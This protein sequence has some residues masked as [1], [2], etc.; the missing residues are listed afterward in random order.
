MNKLRKWEK[1]CFTNLNLAIDWKLFLDL[2]SLIL[3]LYILNEI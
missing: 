1:F 2:G 3:K